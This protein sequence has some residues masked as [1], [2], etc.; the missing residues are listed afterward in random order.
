MSVCDEDTKLEMDIQHTT[1]IE[2][3]HLPHNIQEALLLH[4]DCMMLRV[5]GVFL[6]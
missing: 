2:V 6:S 4:T 3:S 1:P 5:F